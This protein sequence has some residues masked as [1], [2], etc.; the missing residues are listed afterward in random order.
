MTVA[1]YGS[2]TGL[3]CFGQ[4]DSSVVVRL[5]ALAG[6]VF[7]AVVV[8]G[9]AYFCVTLDVGLRKVVPLEKQRPA[10]GTRE[11]VGKAV[12]EIEVGGVTALA[13]PAKRVTGDAGLFRVEGAMV[14]WARAIKWSRSRTPSA[15]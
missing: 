9:L 15:P 1:I 8:N 14:T 3:A 13:I 11:R 6:W 12:A 5:A 4:D 2:I 10:E 7:G